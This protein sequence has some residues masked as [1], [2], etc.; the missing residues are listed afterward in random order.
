MTE[1]KVVIKINVDKP[2]IKAVAP[3]DDIVVW[4]WNRIFAALLVFALI[5]GGLFYYFSSNKPQRI[6]QENNI[7]ESAKPIL[8]TKV[9][10]NKSLINTSEKVNKKPQ[11]I[12]E[13][14]PK[15][16]SPKAKVINKLKPLIDNKQDNI[17]KEK[18]KGIIYHN[19]IGRSQLAAE[20]I[21][22]EPVGKIQT[23]V[24][25]DKTQ[26]KAVFFFT[27]INNMKGGTVYHQWFANK[28]LVFKKK[29]NIAG[30]RWRVYTRK[31]ITHQFKGNWEVN[32]IDDA[33]EV[34]SEIKFEVL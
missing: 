20:I 6:E 3:N 8:T 34:Y 30:N 32:I 31:M 9:L 26:A 17:N 15:K 2:N 7:V 5:M 22:R 27:E 19:N 4:H 18:T 25:V 10:N 1:N 21:Q 29:I 16:E 11:N 24:F 23:P 33:G 12:I 28:Q 14:L 13:Y